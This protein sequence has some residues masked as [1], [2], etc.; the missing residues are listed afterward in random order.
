MNRRDKGAVRLGL[1]TS[2]AYS[3]HNFRGPLIRDCVSRGVSVFALAPDYDDASRDAVGALGAEPVDFRLDR[4][5]IRPFRDARDLFALV[6]LLRSLKLDATLSYF[7]K[8]AIYGTLAARLARVPRPYA[9]VEGAGYVYSDEDERRTPLRRRLLRTLVT[10]LYRVGLAGA[11][12]VFFLNDDDIKLFVARRMVRMQQA[13]LL[14][15]I[16][17]ELDHFRPA[18]SVLYPVTFILVGRLLAQKGVHEFVAAARIVRR[19]HPAV[20]FIM[21]GSPDLNPGSIAE[22]DLRRWHADG[23]IEWQAHTSDVR[24]WLARASVF[25]LPS[26]YREGVPRSIQEAM[27]MARPVVTTDMPGCRD[28][29]EPGISGF[30]VPPRDAETLARALVRFVESPQLIAEMGASA[31]KRAEVMFDVRRANGLLLRT[32]GMEGID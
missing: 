27:A 7:I 26:W 24:P 18:P 25:V 4:T 17:V 16:G 15:G 32:M 31:R 2:Q 11:D 28:T 5:A 21:V 14:G 1:I 10:G 9:M 30:L 13:V 6:R 20:R 19:V 3:L 8:P 23:V 12:S 29:I 22:A